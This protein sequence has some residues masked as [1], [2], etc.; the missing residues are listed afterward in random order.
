MSYS[1]RHDAVKK[2]DQKNDTF[3]HIEET[4]IHHSE[5]LRKPIG[6]KLKNER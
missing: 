6:A 4:E 3:D 1:E 2:N 5:H